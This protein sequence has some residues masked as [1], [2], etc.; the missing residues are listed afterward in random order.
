MNRPETTGR[1]APDPLKKDDGGN[2]LPPEASRPG[3]APEAGTWGGE[4]GAGDY[5]GGPSTIR[6]RR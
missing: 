2:A 6:S 3:Q 1:P 4:G 5:D